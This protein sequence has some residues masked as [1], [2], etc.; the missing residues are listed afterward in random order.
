MQAVN[1]LGS[2]LS[3]AVFECGGYARIRMQ[4]VNI[5]EPPRRVRVYRS[6]V[7]DVRFKVL[8]V[9]LRRLHGSDF[10]FTRKTSR[11]GRFGESSKLE[12]DAAQRMSIRGKRK[13]PMARTAYP[14]FHDMRERKGPYR[15]LVHQ[16]RTA[17]EIDHNQ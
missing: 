1:G 6:L 9:K 17:G 10:D 11:F 3:T 15:I 4:R 2:S 8:R 7:E 13:L 12:P 16:P 14:Q 5:L